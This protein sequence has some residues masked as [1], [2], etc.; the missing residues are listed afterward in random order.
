VAK[1]TI[2]VPKMYADHHVQAARSAL[3][4]LDGVE[5][6]TAS[7]AFKRIIISYDPKKVTSDEL[8]NALR[9]AGYAPGEEVEPSPTFEGKEDGSPWFQLL[10]RV[11]STNMLDLEMSGDH[12]KY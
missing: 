6:I 10:P 1:A 11:T 12:R 7:S 3:L 5:D 9:S 2:N 8:E 4:Q